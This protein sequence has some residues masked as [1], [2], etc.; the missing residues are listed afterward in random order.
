[1]C[2][3]CVE[4]EKKIAHFQTLAGR[5]FDPLTIEGR[6]DLIGEIQ[7]QKAALHPELHKQGICRALSTVS[8]FDTPTGHA[9]IRF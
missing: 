4:F 5:I 9:Y 7:A 1:M 6:N 3:K 8:T 2:A